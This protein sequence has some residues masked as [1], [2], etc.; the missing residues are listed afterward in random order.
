MIHQAK[1]TCK[2]GCQAQYQPP[3]KHQEQRFSGVKNGRVEGNV[4]QS[5]LSETQT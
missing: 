1:V 2:I 5:Q 4:K 3:D